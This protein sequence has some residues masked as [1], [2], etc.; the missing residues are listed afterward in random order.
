[1][2][3]K[4]VNANKLFTEFPEI[5]TVQWEAKVIA[6]LKGKDY[7]K[8]LVWRT[9]EGFSVRPF[10]RAENLKGLEYL[11][12]F[13]GEFPFVRGNSPENKWLIRQ[14]ILVSDLKE[15]NRKALDVLNKGVDSLGFILTSG[16]LNS[17]E[18]MELLLKGICL[19]SAEINFSCSC[20]KCDITGLFTGYAGSG[21]GDPK[22]IKASVNNDPLSYWMLRGQ[23]EDASEEA[24]FDRLKD[25]I[26]KGSSF[27]ELRNIA[28]N[29]KFFGN[30]GSSIVQELAFSVS[31]GVEYLHRLTEKG[32]SPDEVAQKMKFNMSVSNNYFMEIAR[33]RA[34]RLLW[35]HIIRAFGAEK[36]K[37]M[38]MIIH[39]ETGSFNKTIYDPYVNLLRT[40]TEA[41]SAALGGAHS[42]TVL[43]FD[44]FY[45]NP[46][47][48]SERIARNQQVLLKEESSLD[49]TADVAGGS[50]YI[51]NLT[52]SIAEQAWNLFLET[53]DKGGFISAL[54][55]GL[56]QEKIKE[57][58][59]RKN[60][61]L[62]T[63]R[64]N[65]L[66]IN[67][68]PDFREVITDK[69]DDAFFHP[70][71]FSVETPEIVTLRPYRVSQRFESLRYKTDCDSVAHKRPAVFML[72]IGNP[73]M[74]M[75]RAQFSCNFFAAAGFEVID[76]NGFSSVDDGIEA[77]RT[78]R[79]DIIVICS[80]DEE[81]A[82]LVPE[83][84]GKVNDRI[85]VVA[86]NPACRPDLEAQGVTNFIHARSNL[87][88]ELIKYQR[89]LNI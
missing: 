70:S 67:Q 89:I 88:D 1:M 68:F 27:P 58:A 15:A 59:G 51:E 25:S 56:I 8:N 39:C 37:S 34:A 35:A 55:S 86:G 79:A 66:G 2:N 29:G 31:M 48:F 16:I 20:N 64:E 32:L 77:A 85:I 82:L 33:L 22:K 69:L 3:Y 50:Y 53:E 23:F 11:Q 45:Q 30:S 74:R 61:N 12:S 6:D 13:P 83:L 87:L 72:T 4:M 57:S 63:R 71:D 62:D 18:S 47:V 44:S 46:S 9:H 36:E 78:A 7:E 76:N 73:A 10:Y 28:V 49:K 19:E 26:L 14:D 24:A 81:Y 5:P 65:L 84:A 80:S 38:Q 17:Q 41:M 40:Q 75:A 42:I 54:R 43:P 52:A 60:Q 21:K